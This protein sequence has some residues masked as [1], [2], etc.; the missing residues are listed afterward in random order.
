VYDEQHVAYDGAVELVAMRSEYGLSKDVVLRRRALGTYVY[1]S[2]DGRDTLELVVVF[3]TN[4]AV[5]IRINGKPMRS[6]D[7]KG[8]RSDGT[9]MFHRCT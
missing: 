9:W 8:I 5:E 7:V 4:Q 3:E 1:K 2:C 6:V